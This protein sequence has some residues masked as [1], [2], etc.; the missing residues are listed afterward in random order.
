MKVVKY[1]E[2]LSLESYRTLQDEFYEPL[3]ASKGIHHYERDRKTNEVTIFLLDSSNLTLAD[4]KKVRKQFLKTSLI[5]I[6]RK[7][8][9]DNVLNTFGIETVTMRRQVRIRNSDLKTF[10]KKLPANWKITSIQKPEKRK[11]AKV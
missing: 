11:N 7:D 6:Q 10:K 3:L 4:F 9:I 8:D 1:T 2:D 5:T